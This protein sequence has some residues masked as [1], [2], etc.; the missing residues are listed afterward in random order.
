MSL[1]ALKPNRAHRTR[2]KR[3]TRRRGRILSPGARGAKQTT[4]HGPLQ[5]LLGAT[6]VMAQAI[7]AREKRRRR[8]R[9]STKHTD[10]DIPKR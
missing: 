5:R 6:R 2:P 4:H 8:P 9:A 1:A 10:E 3:P 7:R